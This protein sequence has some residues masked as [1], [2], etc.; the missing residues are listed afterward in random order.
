MYTL[1][2]TFQPINLIDSFLSKAFLLK[3]TRKA[4]IAAGVLL[5]AVAMAALVL[6]VIAFKLIKPIYQEI[7]MSF[8]KYA[9]KSITYKVSGFSPRAILKPSKPSEPAK[10]IQAPV[11]RP[12]TIEVEATEIT[13][14]P[15]TSNST[16]VEYSLEDLQKIAK[17]NKVKGWN[18]F[19]SA[20]KLQAKLES[21]GIV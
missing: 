16:G 10:V 4:L 15:E 17:D 13:E 3:L 20:E 9:K 8:P 7:K 11:A 6:T 5:M 18:F 21:L 2:D 1:A 19:K 14:A 12:I